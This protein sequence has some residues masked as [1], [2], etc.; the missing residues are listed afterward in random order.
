MPCC[1][2]NLPSKAYSILFGENSKEEKAIPFLGYSG[3]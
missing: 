1:A 2:R 3:E